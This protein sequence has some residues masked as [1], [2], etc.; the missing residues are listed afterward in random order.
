MNRE[1]ARSQR[2][3][4]SVLLVLSIGCGGG[5]D[6]PVPPTNDG[7]L[8]ERVVTDSS[9]DRISGDVG[10]GSGEA[11]DDGAVDDGGGDG[12]HDT[13]NLTIVIASPAANEIRVAATR[14]TPKVDVTVT[15]DS[16]SDAAPDT[17]SGVTASVRKAGSTT[18]ETSAEL[19]ETGLES[20]PET[21]TK[22]HHFSDTPLDIA[23]LA[24]GM[25]ELEINARTRGGDMESVTRVF[26]I[27]AG[28]VIRI[29]SPEE[30]QYYRDAVTINVTVTDPMFG[31]VQQVSMFLGQQALTFSGPSNNQY[32]GT[33]QFDGFD[34]PLDGDQLLT[35]RA[36]N[37]NGTEAVARQR[38]I[39]DNDGPV[40]SAT[41]PETGALIGRVI[42]I[43][44]EVNDPA[45]VLESSV[46]AVIAHGDKMF[47]VKL[48]P[49][50]VGSSSMAYQALFDTARLPV[51][52]LF[53]S[54]SFRASDVLGNQSSV[55]YLVSLDNTP[56]LADLDPPTNFRMIRNVNRVER[57]SNTFDPL[58][59]DAVD[60]GENVNQLF[61]VRARIEDQGNEPLFGGTDFT[62]IAGIDN[63]RA[64]LLILN[65]TTK[66]L[67]VDTNGDGLCDSVNPLLTPTTT[68]MSSG[69]ALLVNLVPIPPAG[70]SD[71]RPGGGVTGICEHGDSDN[72]P[73]LRCITSNLTEVLYY[74]STTTPAI[75]GI[76]PVVTDNLQC[77][78]RQF[79]TLGNHVEDGWVCLAVAVADTLGNLQV[80]RPLRVCV[81]KD[82]QGNE[83][84]AGRPAIPNCTGTQ[85]ASRP[86]VVVDSTIA[87]QPWA[88]FPASEIRRSR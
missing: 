41:V 87:C 72:P 22:I 70:D 75:Y 59:S 78:G 79:D 68:P 15:S 77:V 40:I 11:G 28:P 47:E 54:I 50:A 14:F 56:P 85:T 35:V 51:N 30:N 82:G 58:G 52:A 80:S 67:V 64:Q 43:S 31:P 71:F 36:S 61:D 49:P 57:C 20:V 53:P 62:P 21:P 32:S 46:V 7:G 5:D 86:N 45:G 55:G 18:V 33:I 73:D 74:A 10:D 9:G 1:K 29:D 69:D 44:A 6:Y 23:K 3:L 17:L 88:A 42:T 38:F 60:D 76:P 37:V 24:S 4:L 83:C 27:D 2:L 81:D 84:G 19:K 63:T 13:L 25:Y 34:P 65:D 12:A 39:S 8:P 48:E 16:S 26:R 66:A